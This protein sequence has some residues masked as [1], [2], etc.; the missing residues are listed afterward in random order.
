M[1]PVGLGEAVCREP[2]GER[3]LRRAQFTHRL[4]VKCA[5]ERIQK[6]A[7][8]QSI[9]SVS[10]IQR[11]DEVELLP[12]NRC[13][14]RLNPSR[15]GTLRGCVNDCATLGMEEVRCQQNRSEAAPGKCR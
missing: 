2:A 12:I 3:E 11:S 13:K 9:E 6:I 8:Q 10:R 14:Q 1:L 5:T 7:R 15:V 4:A